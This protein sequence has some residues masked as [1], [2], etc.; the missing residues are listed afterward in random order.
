MATL[1][2]VTFSSS[3]LRAMNSI[4]KAR[5]DLDKIQ[6]NISTGKKIHRP[7]DGPLEWYRVFSLRNQVIAADQY[8]KNI[9][10]GR[11]QLS[12][13]ENTLQA[14]EN[15]VMRLK[16]LTLQAN[17]GILNTNDKTM[18]I[19]EIRTL[20]KQ[21]VEMGNTRFEG[22]FIFGG[23][24]TDVQPFSLI[25]EDV[26]YQA[27]VI[28][29]GNDGEIKVLVSDKTQDA[30]IERSGVP[31]S[32]PPGALVD[33]LPGGVLLNGVALDPA[34]MVDA[35]SYA[36]YGDENN[37]AIAVAAALNRQSIATGVVASVEPNKVDLPD[38]YRTGVLTASLTGGADLRLNGVNL[39]GRVDNIND[40][41]N[42]V[43]ESTGTHGVVASAQGNKLVLSAY[44]G[45][46]ITLE[47]SAAGR[48][49]AGCDSLGDQVW[50]STVKLNAYS[51]VNGELGTAGMVAGDTLAA[52]DLTI[53][54]VSILSGG[55][56][57]PVAPA[58]TSTLAELL[59]TINAYTDQTGVS[60]VLNQ[61]GD[62]AVLI[63]RTGRD[64][65]V[66]ASATGA[67]IGGLTEG[68]VKYQAINGT[69]FYFQETVPNQALDGLGFTDGLIS[70]VRNLSATVKINSN[71]EELFT[72]AGLKDG[73]NIYDTINGIIYGL[74][75]EGTV[76]VEGS[77]AFD[78]A[79]V[80]LTLSGQEF[81]INGQPITSATLPGG[82][83]G[84]LDDLVQAVNDSLPPTAGITATVNQDGTRI[85]LLADPGI[86][87]HISV[88]SPNAEATGFYQGEQYHQPDFLG[89]SL[90]KLDRFF[91]QVIQV[92]G[93]IGSR[94]ASLETTKKNLEYEGDKHLESISALEDT[95]M[96]EAA[97]MLAQQ[98]SLFQTILA[99][100]AKILQ[101]SLLDFLR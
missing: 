16:E 8:Q 49:I 62:G 32:A 72:G 22:K 48:A 29:N 42:L 44:D 75:E 35:S 31:A 95:D 27:P 86:D 87:V 91:N 47:G 11:S 38:E 85:C 56:G 55:G 54:G 21:I 14:I 19:E 25:P 81:Q 92:R 100:T 97:A 57:P 4:G 39:V 82:V 84:D 58:T 65:L 61:A 77:K 90:E 79:A 80:P 83:I 69:G 9:E 36:A 3:Y 24:R 13:T 45:R 99:A 59:A 94:M 18:I 33:I 2:N 5:T 78:L 98:Q 60:A 70:V 88:D 26:N 37:S 76:K 67:R 40:L 6:Q 41:I 20:R 51:H 12:I 93:V 74:R 43:N 46:N 73:V 23:Y 68:V 101:P 96:I 89:N 63:D 64:M 7:S 30:F 71:G 34:D 28:Y 66:E 50:R 1:Y 10:T 52:G 15:S 53:N 17:S